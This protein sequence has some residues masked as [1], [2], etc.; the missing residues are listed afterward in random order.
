MASTL[1]GLQIIE[2]DIDMFILSMQIVFRRDFSL[3][4]MSEFIE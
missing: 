1:C 3:Y 4:T 2:G